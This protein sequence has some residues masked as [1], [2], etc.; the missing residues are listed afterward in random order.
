MYSTSCHNGCYKNRGMDLASLLLHLDGS[1]TCVDIKILSVK[2]IEAPASS[3][4]S[5]AA[6]I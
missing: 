3:N 5:W 1:T 2:E 4:L 6:L